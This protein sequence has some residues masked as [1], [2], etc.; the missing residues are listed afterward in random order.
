MEGM[1]PGKEAPIAQGMSAHFLK[2][3]QLAYMNCQ[4]K[5]IIKLTQ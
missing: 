3:L 2:T 5:C 4:K 1:Q